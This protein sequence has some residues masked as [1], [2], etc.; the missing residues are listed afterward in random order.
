MARIN[1]EDDVE[2][3]DEFWKLLEVHQG[4]RDRTLGRLVRFFR[5]AQQAWGYA[6]PMSEEKIRAKGFRDMID[7]G[8]A[9]LE[10]GGYHALGAPKHFDWYRQRVV[11]GQSRGD[12][13][14]DSAGRFL[15]SG[16]PADDQRNVIP[17]QPLSLSLSPSLK[18]KSCQKA[19]P[20]QPILATI[21]NANCGNLPSVR[22]IAGTRKQM[23][24]ARWAEVPDESY[25]KSIVE[26]I[27]ASHFCQGKKN[28][29]DSRHSTWRAN[30]QFFVRPDTHHKVMEGQYDNKTH[31]SLGPLH[32]PKAAK[33]LPVD[34]PMVDPE[35]VRKIIASQFPNIG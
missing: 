25:W 13:P 31:P 27:A 16:P 9:V 20:S 15:S 10:Q 21:W 2:S 8:W 34:E 22:G 18:K 1:F 5:M 23:A 6:E 30:F 35:E 17:H 11:A 24:D 29:P 7:T 14:R 33:R 12:A 26:R 3:Q 32:T 28:D 19:P 4:D